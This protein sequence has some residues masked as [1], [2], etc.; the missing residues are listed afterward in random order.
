MMIKKK[1][2]KNTLI[3]EAQIGGDQKL[4]KIIGHG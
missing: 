4:V 2:K 1:K 3:L